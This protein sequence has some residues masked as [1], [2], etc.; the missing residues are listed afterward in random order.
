MTANS[1]LRE[2]SIAFDHDVPS[3]PSRGLTN[4]LTTTYF[5]RHLAG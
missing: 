3:T 5:L 2:T 1:H 4:C